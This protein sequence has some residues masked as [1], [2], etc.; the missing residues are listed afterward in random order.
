MTHRSSEAAVTR[1]AALVFP[2]QA[3]SHEL[4]GC[5]CYTPILAT[6]GAARCCGLACQVGS[7]GKDGTQVYFLHMDGKRG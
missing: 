5:S 4:G 1:H 6:Q 3:G 7:C 2:L